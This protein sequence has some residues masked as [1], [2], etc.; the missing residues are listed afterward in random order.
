MLS[1]SNDSGLAVDVGCR[2]P[3]CS[4]DSQSL[5]KGCS[6][7]GLLYLKFV[8]NLLVFKISSLPYFASIFFLV[9]SFG[10]VEK[11]LSR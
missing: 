6:E 3:E 7:L 5:W 1:F 8:R 9:V 2:S 11:T 4:G 10:S